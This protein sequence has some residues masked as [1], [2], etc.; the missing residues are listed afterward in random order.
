MHD[1]TFKFKHLVFGF[2]V[3]GFGLTVIEDVEFLV[4]GV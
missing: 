2:R 4:W 3:S 1:L